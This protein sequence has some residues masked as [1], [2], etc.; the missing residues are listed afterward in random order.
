MSSEKETIGGRLRSERLSLEV[1]QEPFAVKGGVTVQTQRK[2]EGNE[3]FPDA[4]YLERIA[5][6]GADIGYIVTGQR[7]RPATNG[8]AEEKAAYV[9]TQAMHVPIFDASFEQRTGELELSDGWLAERGLQR[10]KVDSAV[11]QGD[12]MAPLLNNGE[13]FLYDRANQALTSGKTYVIRLLK[14]KETVVARVQGLPGGVRLNF[15]NKQYPPVD[16][17]GEDKNDIAVMGCVVMSL[18]EWN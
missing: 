18:R 1:K 3:R 16:V 12:M 8:V 10:D 9:V 2:Y 7:M 11:Y 15:E 17:V 5:K 4:R 13:T 6:L 14:S